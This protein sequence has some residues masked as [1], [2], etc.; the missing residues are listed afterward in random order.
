MMK[1]ISASLPPRAWIWSGR[2][3]KQEMFEKKRKLA[4]AAARKSREKISGLDDLSGPNA[5]RE[6][7][8]S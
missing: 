2:R 4:S 7:S 3:K 5:P 1:P 6:R 8:M